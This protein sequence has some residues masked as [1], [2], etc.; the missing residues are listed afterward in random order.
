MIRGEEEIPWIWNGAIAGAA[1]ERGGNGTG[2]T[3]QSMRK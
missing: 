1:R 2:R 3:W